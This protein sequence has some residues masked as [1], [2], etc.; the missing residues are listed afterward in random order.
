[1]PPA[2]KVNDETPLTIMA[3][4]VEKG[5]SFPPGTTLT[6]V[7]D[8]DYTRFQALLGMTSGTSTVGPIEILVDEE[9]IWSSLS[10]IGGTGQFSLLT[11]PYQLDLE[12]PMGAS[13]MQIK[14][15]GGGGAVTFGY[16]GFVK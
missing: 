11:R 9:V 13:A 8:P 2:D 7:L 4:P 16:A 3:L 15:G 5:Y 12:L 10:G 6:Y 1:M 14:T